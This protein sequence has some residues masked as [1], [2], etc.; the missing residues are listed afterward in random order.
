M[1]LS[2]GVYDYVDLADG[3]RFVVTTP[4]LN[5]KSFTI[6]MKL[7]FQST[8]RQKSNILNGGTSY[9]WFGLSRSDAGNLS[10]EKVPQE[11][12]DLRSFAC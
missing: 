10:V 11:M 9:R 6:A 3:Q 5:F 2:N 8:E 7:K 1:F 12:R 4:S